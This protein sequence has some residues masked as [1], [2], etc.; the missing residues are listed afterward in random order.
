[1]EGPETEPDA[2]ISTAPNDVNGDD[3]ALPSPTAYEDAC[4]LVGAWCGRSSGVVPPALL[5]R[6]D[7]PEVASNAECPATPAEALPQGG[8]F[9]GV[10]LV[11]PGP[12]RPLFAD[13]SADRRRSRAT[14][15]PAPGVG[16]G[17]GWHSVKTLWFSPATYQGPVL[18]RGQRLDE[19]GPVAFG[20]GPTSAWLLGAPGPT[21]NGGDEFRQWPGGTFVRSPGCYGFQVDGDD[22]SYS[23]VLR[24]VRAD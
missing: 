17:G 22:F 9:A 2:E 16:P 19:P 14:M 6:L 3:V 23:L 7:L 10:S 13:L 1:M 20:E 12:V 18:I 15:K 24:I 21:I 8:Q 4:S 5:R 11:A